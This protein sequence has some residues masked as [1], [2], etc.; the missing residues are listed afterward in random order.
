M[1]FRLTQEQLKDFAV[2][3]CSMCG[4]ETVVPRDTGIC[5][6]CIF[7]P[8]VLQEVVARKIAELTSGRRS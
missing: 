4:R 1:T 5:G 3:H 7:K 8:G 6:E 2:A